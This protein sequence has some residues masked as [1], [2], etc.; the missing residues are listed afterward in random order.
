M[1]GLF[2]NSSSF[3]AIRWMGPQLCHHYPRHISLCIQL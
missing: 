2:Y 3:K 1:H